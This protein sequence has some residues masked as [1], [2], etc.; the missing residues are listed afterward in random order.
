M[1]NG[2]CYLN[3][4]SGY[5]GSTSTM[6]CI[7]CSTDCLTCDGPFS[8]NCLTCVFPKVLIQKVCYATCPTFTYSSSCLPCD[9]S[10]LTCNG[11]SSINCLSCS[12]S[13]FYHLN[14]SKCV[15]ECV[16]G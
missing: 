7:T 8:D 12:S 10:C 11:P 2:L 16:T 3:C 15:T 9:P 5:Y 14:Y 4:P 6:L 1:L 13:K